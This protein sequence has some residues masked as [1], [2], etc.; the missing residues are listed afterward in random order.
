[1]HENQLS[2]MSEAIIPQRKKGFTL[3][4]ILV[5]AG[6]LSIFMTGIFSIYRSSSRGFVTGSWRAEE[7][8]KAQLFLSALSR[9]LSMA[10]SG[11]MR[12][13]SDGSQSPVQATPVYVN[14]KLF[15]FNNSPLFMNTNTNNWTCLFAFSISYPYLAANATFTTPV[16]PGRWS[17]VSVWAKN[18]KVRYVRTGSPVK[19]SSTPVG[20]PGAIVQFPGPGIVKAG[21]A[22]LPDQAQNRNRDF[23]FSL[24]EI[25]CIA[26]GTNLASPN[27]MEIICRF[28]RYENGKKTSSEIVQNA[29]IK[30]ASMTSI[31]SF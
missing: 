30:L 26:S 22:F 20:L 10:N 8:K 1:M 12:I 23:D 5:A 4:E 31:V 16:E 7:Q 6:V 9:D 17:G 2:N 25:A 19:Y 24:E 14:S 29:A 28:V 15:R 11:L 3:V 13:E 21:G 27:G 18:R